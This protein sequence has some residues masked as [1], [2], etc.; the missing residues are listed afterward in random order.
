M[1]RR[2]KNSSI[3]T[4]RNQPKAKYCIN[5]W[6]S[7]ITELNLDLKNI[8][9]KAFDE[10]A[11]MNGVHKGLSTRMEECSPLGIYVHCCGH[12]LNLALQDTITQIEPLR[13]ALWTI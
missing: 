6:K 13:N 2:K 4:P 1:E 3:S 11:N 9:G 12:V 7:A 10:A 5:W 8:V